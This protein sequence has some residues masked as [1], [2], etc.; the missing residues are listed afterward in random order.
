MIEATGSFPSSASH[1]YS[2]NKQGLI[3]IIPRSCGDFF[4][5][6]MLPLPAYACLFTLILSHV[7]SAVQDG[8]AVVRRTMH[9]AEVTVKPQEG[10]HVEAGASR[11]GSSGSAA[12][13]MRKKARSWTGLT[14]NAVCWLRSRAQTHLVLIQDATIFRGFGIHAVSSV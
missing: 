11:R 5:A 9:K 12:Q 8:A 3:T 1:S 4:A 7:V 2:G 6:C 14:S 10:S 13:A